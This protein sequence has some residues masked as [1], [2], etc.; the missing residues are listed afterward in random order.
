M[1]RIF[2]YQL[3][4]R[5]HRDCGR[6]LYHI[7]F[8]NAQNGYTALI[9]AARDGKPDCV[10]LLLDA[11]VNKDAKDKVSGDRLRSGRITV[12]AR[13]CVFG[14][15]NFVDFLFQF[16]V[17]AMVLGALWHILVHTT[18]RKNSRR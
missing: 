15:D 5:L 18:R 1:F 9:W 11:G 14:V 16:D 10:R 6:L 2:W 7:W 13:V 8:E 4:I 17:H 3:Y 12:C